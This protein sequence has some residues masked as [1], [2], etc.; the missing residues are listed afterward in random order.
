MLFRSAATKGSKMQIGM[1]MYRFLTT[2]STLANIA[3]PDLGTAGAMEAGITVKCGKN[4]NG[5]LSR[6]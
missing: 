1:E 5:E 6:R 4:Q 3:S 2:R